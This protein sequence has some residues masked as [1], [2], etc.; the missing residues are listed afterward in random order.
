[1]RETKSEEVKV[2][3]KGTISIERID[4]KINNLLQ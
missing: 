3:R 2:K 4:R 1:M